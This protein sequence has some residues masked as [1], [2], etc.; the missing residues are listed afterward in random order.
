MTI[1]EHIDQVASLQI[2]VAEE[3]QWISLRD[4]KQE[5]L[6]SLDRLLGNQDGPNR[7]KIAA[8][9]EIAIA[10]KRMA[11]GIERRDRDRERQES[12]F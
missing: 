12:E 10:A 2:P 4:Q 9:R 3:R 1:R 6:D 11:D 8:L 7:D 5:T